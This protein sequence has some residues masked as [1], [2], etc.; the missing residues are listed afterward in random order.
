MSMNVTYELSENAV[1]TLDCDLL[2]MS[3]VL[4]PYYEHTQYL[5]SARVQVLGDPCDMGHISACCTFEIPESCY[6]KNTGHF[7]SVEFNI[8]YNQMMYYLIAKSVK[9]QLMSAFQAW[10]LDDYF[11][12]QL[13]DILIVNF[14]SKFKRPI[15]GTRFTGEIDFIQT[16]VKRITNPLIYLTSVCRFYDAD[17]GYCEGEIDLVIMNSLDREKP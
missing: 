1:L 16:K 17:N 14:K 7:N 8:C 9:H 3:Q 2:L 10:T 4:V 5:K 15:C 11:I 6:I 12:K 13:P